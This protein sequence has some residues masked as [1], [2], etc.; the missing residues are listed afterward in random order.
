MQPTIMNSNRP[1]FARFELREVEDR[2]ASLQNG[3][4]T[5]KSVVFALITPSGSRDVVEKIAAEWLQQLEQFV[6]EDRFP[7]NWLEYYREQHKR[8]V[9]G[10]EPELNGT[11]IRNWAVASPSQQ[12]QMR[13]IGIRTVEDLANANEEALSRLGM[14]ARQLK[15][16]AIVWVENSTGKAVEA[17]QAAEEA[18][19]R[20]AELEAQVAELLKAKAAPE[21]RPDAAKPSAPPAAQKL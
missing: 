7:P 20:V 11:D 2:E 6:Q 15:A 3:Y 13:E 4:Y 12:R 9:Q 18:K 17:Q 5:T 19:R 14:G 21:S 1:P 10:L 8:F 16:Q